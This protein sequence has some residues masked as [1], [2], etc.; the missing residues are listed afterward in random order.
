MG[1]TT[2]ANYATTTSWVPSTTLTQVYSGT[3]PTMTAGT[4]VEIPLTT[5]FIWNGT[6]N[7]VIAVDENA[8][9]YS[10]TAYWEAIMQG[11]TEVYYITVTV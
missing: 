5:P 3:M 11:Q 7:I 8:P 9:D 1:N 4:W 10:C 6:D 2:Q